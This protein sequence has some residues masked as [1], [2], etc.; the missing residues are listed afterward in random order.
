MRYLL[1]IAVF[2]PILGALHL[3][4][5]AAWRS[6]GRRNAIIVGV[7]VAV[8][9][10]LVLCLAVLPDGSKL[11]LW[12]LEGVPLLH[13]RFD[14]FAR[15]F[16]LLVASLWSLTSLYSLAYMRSKSNQRTYYTFFVLSLGV[17]LG[18][19]LAANLLALYV[20][21]EFLTL[22]TFPL[23]VHRHSPRALAAGR[24][25]LVYSF[26]GAAFILY[27]LFRTLHLAGRLDFVPGGLL[28]GLPGVA[29]GEAVSIL[30][31]LVVGFGVKAAIVPLHGWLPSAMVAP[32]PVSALLHAVAVVKSG[33]FAIMRVLFFVFGAGLLQAVGGLSWLTALVAVSTLVGS[34]LALTQDNLKRRLA[35]STISQ[36][37]YITLG[38]SLL[39][40]SGLLGGLFHLVTHALMKMLLFF[41]AG[42]VAV[43]TGKVRVSEMDGTGRRAPLVMSCLAIGVAGMIGLPPTNGFV[44]K[45]YLSLGGLEAGRTWVVALLMVSAF[46]NAAYFIPI[47]VRAFFRPPAGSETVVPV[48]PAMTFTIVALTAGVVLT[49]LFPGLIAWLV[50]GARRA[51]WP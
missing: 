45:W 28:A 23:V 19:A 26:M 46:L 20:F 7:P 15:L 51:A 47:V 17:T 9:A 30:W 29:P 48:P 37:A 10:L 50:E 31:P 2:L 13:L 33:A 35:Y 25:Y 6:E 24:K 43:T 5:E 41:C 27:G 36:L 14:G 40:P 11:A 8:T 18:V 42:A 1:V 3:R 32:T 22:S 49:G 21:Y 12:S 44:S 38:A 16:S 34:M 4:F 39:T